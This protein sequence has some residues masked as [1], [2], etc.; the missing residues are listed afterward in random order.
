MDF[1]RCWYHR[2]VGADPYQRYHVPRNERRHNWL[3]ITSCDDKTV[4][5]PLAE[6][7]T[8]TLFVMM[9]NQQKKG[10]LKR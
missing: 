10:I 8:S 2:L 9:T 5:I 6:N 1:A 7:F 4:Q 3:A